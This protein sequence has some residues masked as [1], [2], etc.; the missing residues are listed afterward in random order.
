MRERYGWAVPRISE[1][2]P[3]ED[4]RGNRIIGTPVAVNAAAGVFFNA[5]NCVLEISEGVTLQAGI[6]FHQD[7]GRVQIGKRSCLRGAVS[8][9]SGATVTIGE[10]L[11]VTGALTIVTDDQ[12]E[13][14][15]GD[16]CMFAANVDLRAYD[17]HPI[18]DLRTGLRT[19]YARPIF[20]GNRVWMGLGSAAL[21]GAVVGD[22]SIIGYRSVV[23][24]GRPVPPHCLA[25]GTPATVTKKYVAWSKDGNPPSPELADRH[26][27]PSPADLPYGGAP[28]GDGDDELA[29][30][31]EMLKSH[32][33]GWQEGQD[34]SPLPYGSADSLARYIAALSASSTT[35]P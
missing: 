18:Y 26:T 7:G 24:A 3:Y 8:I 22:G 21:G 15:I 34:H 33:D 12:A 1:I 6:V 30:A 14:F 32:M 19:N 4:D 13:V 11:S 31:R 27:Y 28:D 20:I 17:N 25:V 2:A 10:R 29:R 9:G 5:S 16:D 23:T 35:S